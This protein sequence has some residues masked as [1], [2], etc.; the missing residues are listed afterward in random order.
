MTGDWRRLALAALAATAVAIAGVP[1]TQA[2]AQA[3]AK[4]DQAKEA[5]AEQPADGAEAAT[6]KPA[7]KRQDPVEA[8][9]AIEAALKLLEVGKPDQATQTLTT[10]L[11]GGNLPP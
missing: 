11:N 5:D 1:H 3:A 8:Q 9:H 6:K 2:L 10:V 7:R 4:K